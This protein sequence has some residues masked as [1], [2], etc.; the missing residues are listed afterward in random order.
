MQLRHAILFGSL[1][2]P[3][4]LEPLPFV[5]DLDERCKGVLGSEQVTA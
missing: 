4:R 1:S 3:H 5:F 2:G